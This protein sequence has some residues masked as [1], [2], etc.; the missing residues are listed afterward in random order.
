MITHELLKDKGIL[1]VSPSGALS[2]S[3][4]E[5]L[6]DAVAPAHQGTGVSTRLL[7]AFVERARSLSKQS[8]PL[9]CKDGLVGYY[10]RFGFQDLG[11]S[12]SSHGGFRWREMRRVL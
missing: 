7:N 1:V 11:P 12:G 6:A 3:D 9:L 4:F 10:R 2:S 5:T 8:I